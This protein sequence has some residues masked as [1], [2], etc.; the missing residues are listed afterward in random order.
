M[1]VF[2]SRTDSAPFFRGLPFELPFRQFKQLPLLLL[3]LGV[4]ADHHDLAF[5]LDDLALIADFLH[6]GFDL[7]VGHLSFLKTDPVCFISSGT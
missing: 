1:V 3:V 4:F 7:H 5:S 6:R 2:F